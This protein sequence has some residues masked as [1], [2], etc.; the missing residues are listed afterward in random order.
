MTP[1]ERIK[2]LER[3]VEMMERFLSFD[4]NTLT[5]HGSVAIKGILNLQGATISTGLGSPEGVVTATVGSLFLSRNGSTSNT[6]YVK[7]GGSGSSGWST[8]A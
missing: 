8:T 2:E 4:T 7:E 5:V 6:L 1:E 3:K